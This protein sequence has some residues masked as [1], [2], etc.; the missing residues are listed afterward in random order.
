[1]PLAHFMSRRSRGG[2]RRT[3]Y[4]PRLRRQACGSTL[5]PLAHFVSRH[6]LA[7]VGAGGEPYGEAKDSPG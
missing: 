7:G 3:A 2:R 6:M 4:P 5:A 1:A